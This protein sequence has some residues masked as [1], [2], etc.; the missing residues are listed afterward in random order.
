MDDD[1]WFEVRL[2]S[3]DDL[4]ADRGKGGKLK[5][6]SNLGDVLRL[7]EEGRSDA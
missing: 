3:I 5:T 2:K 7:L 1:P 4:I 6:T